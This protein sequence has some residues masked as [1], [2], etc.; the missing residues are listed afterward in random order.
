VQRG[1]LRL[2]HQHSVLWGLSPVSRCRAA[3]AFYLLT[4]R[5]SEGER[6]VRP[7]SFI[8][9]LLICIRRVHACSIIAHD[10]RKN[11]TAVAQKP[12]RM[13]NVNLALF[14]LYS[15]WV[16]SVT[17]SKFLPDRHLSVIAGFSHKQDEKIIKK[18][19]AIPGI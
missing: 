14:L 8:T 5:Q 10:P 3:A 11:A 9:F 1:T 19:A 2:A 13:R 12:C 4:G 15:G 17:D 7:A 18:Q 16:Q 6:A